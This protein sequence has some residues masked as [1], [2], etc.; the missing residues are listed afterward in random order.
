[1]TYFDYLNDFALSGFF[2]LF[3]KKKVKI[4]FLIVFKYSFLK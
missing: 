3:G 2:G 4:C 1:M